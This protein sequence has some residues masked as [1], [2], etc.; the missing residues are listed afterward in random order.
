MFVLTIG[1]ISATNAIEMNKLC[2]IIVIKK[3]DTINFYINN[4]D[5]PDTTVQAVFNPNE[6][7]NPLTIGFAYNG[8]YVP[9]A[10]IYYIKIAK[11]AFT[12]EEI[13]E[14]FDKLLN[15]NEKIQN[16]VEEIITDSIKIASFDS[17]YGT[18]EKEELPVAIDW[19]TL[20]FIWQGNSE[21]NEDYVRFWFNDN[22]ELNIKTNSGWKKSY[23]TKN[24][25]GYYSSLVYFFTSDNI[26]IVKS[27]THKN[28]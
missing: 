5:N 7:G 20:D 23:N 9:T 4:A 10:E 15:L 27:L 25:L 28:E 1:R 17:R 19:S 24:K 14:H 11:Y 18:I 26:I 3:N 22:Q 13:K 2:T 16:P 12:K 6:T 8:N 21:P